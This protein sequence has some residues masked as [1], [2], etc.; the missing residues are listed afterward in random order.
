MHEEH[1]FDLECDPVY[2]LALC[3][4]LGGLLE[5]NLHPPDEMS[6]EVAWVEIPSP[7]QAQVTLDMAAFFARWGKNYARPYQPDQ[8]PVEV[9]PV[10][11]P[12]EGLWREVVSEKRDHPLCPGNTRAAVTQPTGTRSSKCHPPPPRLLCALSF[13]LLCRSEVSLLHVNHDQICF[14]RV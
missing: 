9:G 11:A 10:F 7:G 1:L 14:L 4:G 5:L 13:R 6:G 3:V 12:S 8:Y 2:M